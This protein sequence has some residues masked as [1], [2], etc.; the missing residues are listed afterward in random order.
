MNYAIIHNM[1][2]KEIKISV[3]FEDGE[4]IGSIVSMELYSFLKQYHKMSA[5]DET[6]DAIVKRYEKQNNTRH[7]TGHA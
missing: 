1:K 7:E 3:V 5:L 4:E 6:F 2:P